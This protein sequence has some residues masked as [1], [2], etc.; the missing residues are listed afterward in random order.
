MKLT[1]LLQIILNKNNEI[2]QFADHL[3]KKYKSSLQNQTQN[4]YKITL[5][6]LTLRQES[7]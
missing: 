6:N 7:R 4:T 5:A 1:K 3:R 2:D